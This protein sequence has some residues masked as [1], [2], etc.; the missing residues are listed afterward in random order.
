MRRNHRKD[1]VPELTAER[2]RE[3][4]DYDP[5]TGVFTHRTTCHSAVKLGSV[6]GWVSSHGYRLI[7]VDG[8]RYYAGR[9]AYLW[10]TGEWPSGEIDHIN[11]LR[12]DNRWSNLRDVSPSENKRNCKRPR[13][14]DLPIG[15]TAEGDK[16]KA[17]IRVNRKICHLGMFQTP[18]A[19]SAAYQYALQALMPAG[20]AA[21]LDSISPPA[22]SVMAAWDGQLLTAVRRMGERSVGV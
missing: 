2:L 4:L 15:V 7:G 20:P 8:P 18:E 12:D 17:Q 5:A 11:R 14:H 19:A 1:S 3:I 21:P 16:F 9:L 6:A 22:A 10:V 13:I